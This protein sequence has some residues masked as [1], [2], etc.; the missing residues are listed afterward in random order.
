MARCL[1]PLP[2]ESHHIANIEC[3]YARSLSEQSVVMLEAWGK[4]YGTNANVRLL[5]RSL[6]KA[7][8]RLQ[9]E[10]VL[11]LSLVRHLADDFEESGHKG[12]GRGTN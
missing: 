1:L 3:E 8:C 11:G 9:A 7:E 12:I 6:L 10:E 2:F 5:C 4:R